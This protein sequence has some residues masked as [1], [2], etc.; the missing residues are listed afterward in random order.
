MMENHDDEKIKELFR[1]FEP[2]PAATS[3]D[4]MQRLQ[5]SMDA[6][7]IVKQYNIA[8]RKRNRLATAIAAFCGFAAGVVMTLLFPLLGNLVTTFSIAIP[9]LQIQSFTIN[10]TYVAWIIMAAVSVI[11]ALNAYELALAKLST[12]SHDSCA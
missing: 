7:E 6:V 12:K 2:E 11:T 3:A 1:N 4:F 10:Y 8:L 5:K 9:H